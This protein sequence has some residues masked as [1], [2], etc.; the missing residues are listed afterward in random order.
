M[1]KLTSALPKLRKH[2][3][4]KQ[5]I[6]T[7]SGTTHYLSLHGSKASFLEYDRLIAQWLSAGRQPLNRQKNYTLSIV[8]LAAAY[9]KHAK[10]YYRKNGK[11]SAEYDCTVAALRVMCELY[12]RSPVDEF[13]P[14]ALKTVRDKMISKEWTRRYINKQIAR[15]RRGFRWA[16][17]NELISAEIPRALEMLEGLKQGRSKAIDRP[18][19]EPVTD[20]I[21]NQTLPHLP[22]VVA[23]MVRFQRLTGARP[24]EVCSL[25]PCHIDFEGDVWSYHVSNHKNAHHNQKRTIQ[26]GPQAQSVLQPYL[27]EPDSYCFSPKKSEAIRRSKAHSQRATPMSCGNRPGTNRKRSPKRKAGEKYTTNSYRRA[28]HRACDGANVA[29][30]SPN[31]LR[32][33]AATEYR[34]KFG[35]EAAQVVLGH[36]TANITE[37]YAERNDDLA[38]RAAREL[39]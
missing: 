30:W 14:L 20:E 8:E 25:K 9:K 5:A 32:H 29:K 2:S 26:I 16:A 11:I 34:K 23:D 1:P 6:V 3:N 39:G 31:Q 15:I 27:S 35:L 36:K 24:G 22:E 4:G 12:S 13:G 10:E 28:V 21:I 17:A 7:L 18:P 19:V 37:I 38:K 33:A